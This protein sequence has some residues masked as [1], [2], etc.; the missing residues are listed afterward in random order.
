MREF[1]SQ[2]TTRERYL[3]LTALIMVSIAIII[4][5]IPVSIPKLDTTNNVEKIKS[6][7]QFLRWANTVSPYLK[8]LHAINTNLTR[9]KPDE[10]K[11]Y[12]IKTL[13]GSRLG[14]A[15]TSVTLNGNQV[16]LRFDHAPFDLL[17]TKITELQLLGAIVTSFSSN[18]TRNSG[19]CNA[20]LTLKINHKG[21]TDEA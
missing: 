18:T 9:A 16:T 3:M 17:I 12:I 7:I 8:S 1:W 11:K 20:L 2:R 6:R 19:Y 15:L 14:E 4:N 5:A 13:Q 21:S 10:W